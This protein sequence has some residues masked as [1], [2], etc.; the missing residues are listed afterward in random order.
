MTTKVQDCQYDIAVKIFKS[1]WWLVT[2]TAPI[3]LDGNVHISHNNCVCCV[4]YKEGFGL[5]I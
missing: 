5:A 3:F 2:R 4:N 1:G